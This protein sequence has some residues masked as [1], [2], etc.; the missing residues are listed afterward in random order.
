MK[1]MVPKLA[2]ELASR[3]MLSGQEVAWLAIAADVLASADSAI[4]LNVGGAPFHGPFHR[5]FTSEM[6]TFPVVIKNDSNQTVALTLTRRGQPVRAAPAIDT[7]VKLTRNLLRADGT[8]ADVRAIRQHE[9]LVV[10]LV[11]NVGDQHVGSYKL[12]APIPAGFEIETRPLARASEVAEFPFIK[13]SIKPKWAE[14]GDTAFTALV[15][16]DKDSSAE[17]MVAYVVR[18]VTPGKFTM[19]EAELSDVDDPKRRGLTPSAEVEIAR[20]AQ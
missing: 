11:G 12:I 16:L 4:T 2:K 10:T 20:A 15:E 14:A 8:L 19:P 13:G 5:R 17:F 6:L 1:T 7:R 18:A 3:T 9:R